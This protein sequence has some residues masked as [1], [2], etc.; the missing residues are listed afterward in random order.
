[1]SQISAYSS[2]SLCQSCTIN[3]IIYI[4]AYK[5]CIEHY[6]LELLLLYDYFLFNFLLFA[7]WLNFYQYI[8]LYQSSSAKAEKPKYELFFLGKRLIVASFL[9]IVLNTLLELIA[10]CRWFEF[11]QRLITSQPLKM[12]DWWINTWTRADNIDKIIDNSYF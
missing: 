3:L 10:C 7:Y 2:F 12:F 6:T 9:F 5:Y 8:L 11:F 4:L 1:M